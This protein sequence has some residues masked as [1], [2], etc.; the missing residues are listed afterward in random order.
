MTLARRPDLAQAEAAIHASVTP[1]HINVESLGSTVPHLHWNIIP[2][3]RSDPRWGR[4]IW[5]TDKIGN[6]IDHAE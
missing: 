6:R 3:Y 1:D 2:R 5:T 4:P